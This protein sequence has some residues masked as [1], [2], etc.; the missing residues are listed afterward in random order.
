M[1]K[2]HGQTPPLSLFG[3]LWWREFCFLVT[4][5]NL[6]YNRM[7]GNPMCTQIPWRR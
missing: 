2:N 1:Q 5:E 3:A 7:V 4:A 6:N